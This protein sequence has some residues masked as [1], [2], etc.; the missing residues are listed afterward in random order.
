MSREDLPSTL[1]F[2]GDISYL[3]DADASLA[4]YI[5]IGGEERPLYSTD[6]GDA[7]R[8][9]AETPQYIII[10]VF[11]YFV[12]SGPLYKV[13]RQD[14]IIFKA[15][16]RF[17]EDLRLPIPMRFYSLFPMSGDP[18]DTRF[19]LTSDHQPTREEMQSSLLERLVKYRGRMRN[20]IFAAQEVMKRGEEGGALVADAINKLETEFCQYFPEISGYQESDPSMEVPYVLSIDDLGL[21]KRGAG[22]LKRHGFETAWDIVKE[23]ERISVA[24]GI[25][26]RTYQEIQSRMKEL[27]FPLPDSFRT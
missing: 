1:R 8:I 3:S 2:R 6:K 10:N 18:Q 12:Q 24:K 17:R 19:T 16:S 22:V 9:K 4:L 27:G 13:H 20:E 23:G 5:E 26:H 7:V 21:S 14:P 25:G 11:C 15:L